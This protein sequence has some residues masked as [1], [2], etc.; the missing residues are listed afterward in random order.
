MRNE[1]NRFKRFIRKLG[2]SRAGRSDGTSGRRPALPPEADASVSVR[3]V[4]LGST[5]EFLQREYFSEPQPKRN[6]RADTDY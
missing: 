4:L 2:T 3:R 5:L 1:D 6:Q